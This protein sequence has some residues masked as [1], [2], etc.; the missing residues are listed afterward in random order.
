M[1]RWYNL[2]EYFFPF[3]FKGTKPSLVTM[4]WAPCVR[5][6]P[7]YWACDTQRRLHCEVSLFCPCALQHKGQR[8][9]TR[10]QRSVT[11]PRCVQWEG[12]CTIRAK[13]RRNLSALQFPEI[14]GT[15]SRSCRDICKKAE[16]W[17]EISSSL[18]K[19]VKIV[20]NSGVMTSTVGRDVTVPSTW[21]ALLLLARPPA[22]DSL[23]INNK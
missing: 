12:I 18:G 22:L 9:S 19:I 21:A 17:E 11:T 5:P 20:T 2:V 1:Y 15:C 23:S 8:D 14:F 7:I 10:A 4:L 3:F 6:F 16:L 13:W